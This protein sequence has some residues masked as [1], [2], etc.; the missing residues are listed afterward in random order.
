MNE[1][2]YIDE[3]LQQQ[4]SH[5]SSSPRQQQTSSP[6]HHVSTEDMYYNNSKNSSNNSSGIGGYGVQQ[7]HSPS[8]SR[9]IQPL[10]TTIAE[11]PSHGFQ[12]VLKTLLSPTVHT[13]KSQ[14]Q[15]RRTVSWEPPLEGESLEALNQIIK[16]KKDALLMRE[17]ELMLQQ[18]MLNENIRGTHQS[19]PSASSSP[20]NS[21][22]RPSITEDGNSSPM[23]PHTAN[24]KSKHNRSKS[25]TNTLV[26]L[27][28]LK[29][30]QADSSSF[31]PI[32]SGEHYLAP[33]PQKSPKILSP[34]DGSRSPRNIVSPRPMS[35]QEYS[36]YVEKQLH[37]KQ[38]QDRLTTTT[39]TTTTTSMTSP[40]HTNY[41]RRKSVDPMTLLAASNSM[42]S[43]ITS[44]SSSRAPPKNILSTQYLNS[45]INM[46]LHELEEEIDK[47][48]QQVILHTKT[49]QGKV[50]LLERSRDSGN[51]KTLVAW[52][53]RVSLGI[54]ITD[55]P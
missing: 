22:F 5:R 11:D 44:S 51:A 47:E 27:H 20:P 42:A 40:I 13:P 25:D 39:T 8:Y 37:Y 49:I 41:S 23:S 54:P 15:H 29:K 45:L 38:Q 26:K 30:Q 2:Q 43:P 50:D 21:N 4:L 19:S 32:S 46:D 16:E 1:L 18:R 31:H 52:N 6:I 36:D 53:I 7:Y 48:I 34:N 14:K 24:I 33:I 9:I 10:E 17:R 35:K 3:E 28:L 55:T 12:P